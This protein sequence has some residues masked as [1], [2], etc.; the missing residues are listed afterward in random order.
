MS[1]EAQFNC[2][3]SFLH[4]SAAGLPEPLIVAFF[5]I[6]YSTERVFLFLNPLCEAKPSLADFVFS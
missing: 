3:P 2:K 5:E 4:D 6:P 1:G